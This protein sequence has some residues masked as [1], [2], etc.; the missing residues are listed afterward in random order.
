MLFAWR[1]ILN[2]KEKKIFVVDNNLSA[3]QFVHSVSAVC[4]HRI[5]TELI[6]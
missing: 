6:L 2:V 5:N 3:E 1:F 4:F